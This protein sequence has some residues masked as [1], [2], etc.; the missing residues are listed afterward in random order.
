MSYVTD[1]DRKQAA[2]DIQDLARRMGLPVGTD[3]APLVAREA[4]RI[5]LLR[6][7]DPNNPGRGAA[8]CGI[9]RFCDIEAAE[10]GQARRPQDLGARYDFCPWCRISKAARGE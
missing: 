2:L 6:L 9:H 10:K 7:A 1:E 8:T 3:L 5:A 4:Q